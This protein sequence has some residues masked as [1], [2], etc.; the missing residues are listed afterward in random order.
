MVQLYNPN[1]DIDEANRP[2]LLYIHKECENL[3]DSIINYNSAG[4]SD[5]ALK[6]FFDILRYLR[7]SNGGMGPDYFTKKNMYVTNRGTGG[8]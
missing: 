3:I 5:E 1:Y 8:Y 7:M 4:K 6:D 2:Q